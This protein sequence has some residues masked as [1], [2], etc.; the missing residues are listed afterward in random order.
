[1]PAAKLVLDY[2]V[3]MK[4]PKKRSQ[5]QIGYFVSTLIPKSYQAYG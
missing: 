2:E 4:K 3:P 5:R 1:M